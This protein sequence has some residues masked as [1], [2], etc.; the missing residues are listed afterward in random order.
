MMTPEM[1]LD[2]A[3][4]AIFTAA[5]L[6]APVLVSSIVV[7]IA[8]N[9]FQTVTSLRDQSLTFAPKLVAAGLVFGLSLPWAINTMTGFFQYVMQLFPQVVGS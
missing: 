9:V 8:V 6:C 7:G 2:I 3:Y 4:A 1:V 5:K